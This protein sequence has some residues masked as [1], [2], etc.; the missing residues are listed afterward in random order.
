[1]NGWKTV[2]ELPAEAGEYVCF[3]NYGDVFVL[4]FEG[5]EWER[6]TRFNSGEK[7]AYWT[8]KPE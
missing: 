6:A 4:R 1:M 3:T 2:D 5:G 7:V 8:Q